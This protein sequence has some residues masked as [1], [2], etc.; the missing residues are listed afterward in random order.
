MKT[1]LIIV[2]VVF[3]AVLY[4]AWMNGVFL[5]CPH[6]RKV[7][8]WRY[9]PAGPP[10]KENDRH[11][12]KRG[13]AFAASQISFFFYKAHNGYHRNEVRHHPPAD[14]PKC[15]PKMFKSAI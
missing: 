9:D 11:C 8:S 6:C 2:A 5:R 13:A 10:V 1:A 4:T 12:G 7:G 15:K 3:A 14:F